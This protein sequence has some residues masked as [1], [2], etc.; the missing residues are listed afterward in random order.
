MSNNPLSQYF[1]QPSIYVKLPSGGQHYADGAIDMPQNGELP[2]YP[3]TAIDE[4]TYRTP[5]A[6][7]NGNAVTN[8]IKSCIPAIRDPWAIP[9]MDVDS[10]LVSIRIASYGHTMEISTT[11]PHCENEADYGLDLRTMLEQMKSPDYTQPVVSGDMQIFFKPMTYKNLNDN[12]QKQF[13][14]QKLLQ[15]LPNSDMLDAEKMTAMSAALIKLTNITIEAIS[16]SI[17][18]VK[19]PSA[20]VSEPEFIEEML[21]N[22][23]R[24]LFTQ[25][26]DH[27]INVKAKA[28]IQPMKLKCSACEKEYQQAVTLDMTSFFGDAS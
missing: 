9:A 8:V 17:A 2:V 11:C 16:Q 25:I 5:D 13:E 26:R 23:D 7:F 21:K 15:V 3:M 14:E 20:L 6:L 12:N 27:I 1:R 18:A 4:I 22:C 28:E 19:T 24:R 10:I